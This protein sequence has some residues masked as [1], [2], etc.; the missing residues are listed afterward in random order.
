MIIAM[1]LFM[2]VSRDVGASPPSYSCTKTEKVILPN[3]V[4]GTYDAKVCSY[5]CVHVA[6]CVEVANV[7]VMKDVFGTA[8]SIDVGVSESQA[9]SFD[10]TYTSRNSVI[11]CQVNAPP[12]KYRLIDNKQLVK[13][14]VFNTYKLPFDYGIR[15]TGRV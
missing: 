8:P 10:N 15:I 1:V 6:P 4:S 9:Y 2:G 12:N 11:T 3:F 5:V 7:I 13:N 14:D